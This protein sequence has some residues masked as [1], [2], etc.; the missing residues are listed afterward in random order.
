MKLK[1]KSLDI[2]TGYPEGEV[3]E[4]SYDELVITP[5][6]VFLQKIEPEKKIEE[7]VEEPVKKAPKKK[8]I[9]KR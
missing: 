1:Y 3:A 6:N 7:I 2:R 4:L 8:T 9:K 5:F